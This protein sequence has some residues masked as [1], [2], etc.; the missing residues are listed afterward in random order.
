[1]RTMDYG[2]VDIPW[3]IIE[4][5]LWR[6]ALQADTYVFG[7]IRAHLGSVEI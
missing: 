1:M 7:F 4:L 3:G 5:V 6:T 2:S